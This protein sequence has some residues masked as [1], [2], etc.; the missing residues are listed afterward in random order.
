MEITDFLGSIR[1]NI[2]SIVIA[3]RLT[4]ILNCDRVVYLDNGEVIGIGSLNELGKQIPDLEK[5]LR[6][7]LLV[8]E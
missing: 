8:R 3:H 1:G 5:Q 7:I 4:S 6:K 2:T